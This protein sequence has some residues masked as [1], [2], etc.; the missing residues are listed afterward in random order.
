MFWVCMKR[1]D[2]PTDGAHAY[3][4][5]LD[6]RTTVIP[7]TK[8]QTVHKLYCITAPHNDRHRSCQLNL[9][10]CSQRLF[11]LHSFNCAT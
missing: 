3:L 8:V 10:T 6:S 9:R 2:V 11:F 7:L 1:Q 5:Y 4:G